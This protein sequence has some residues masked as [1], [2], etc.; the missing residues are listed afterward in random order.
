MT[1][2]VEVELV[3]MHNSPI[4]NRTGR[5][6]AP[7]ARRILGIGA[8][9]PRM[10][11]LLNDHQRDARPIL[12]RQLHAGFLDSPK[13]IHVHLLELPVAH[14]ISVEQNLN[15]LASRAPVVSNQQFLDNLIQVIDDLNR[16]RLFRRFHF[17]VDLSMHDWSIACGLQINARNDGGD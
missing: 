3:R 2:K 16:F 5:D 17:L 10:V 9:K 13:L 6:V 7:L 14:A 1:T 15:R 11:P 12:A 4:N 8:E